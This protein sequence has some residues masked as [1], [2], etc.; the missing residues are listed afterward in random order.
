MPNRVKRVKELVISQLRLLE[1][2]IKHL[3]AKNKYKIL[4]QEVFWVK[5]L[6]T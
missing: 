2:N 4:L 1:M 3:W 5:F 6:K